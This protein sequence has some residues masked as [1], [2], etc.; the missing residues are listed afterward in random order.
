MQWLR[1]SLLV[2]RQGKQISFL[3]TQTSL[4]MTG[5]TAPEFHSLSSWFWE[6]DFSQ[7]SSGND[8]WENEGLL[9][10]Q[11]DF[12]C[13]PESGRKSD[14]L[15]CP[16]QQETCHK[17][18]LF[19]RHQNLRAHQVPHEK[20]QI[21]ETHQH[22]RTEVFPERD[23]CCSQPWLS[24]RCHRKKKRDSSPLTSFSLV[25]LLIVFPVFSACPHFLLS[26]LCSRPLS[27]VCLP[28]ETQPWGRLAANFASCLVYG[29]GKLHSHFL[30]FCLKLA[31]G[32]AYLSRTEILEVGRRVVAPLTSFPIIS[33]CVIIVTQNVDDNINTLSNS[34]NIRTFI[35]HSISEIL[36]D[37][38]VAT[39]ESW[40]GFDAKTLRIL[41]SKHHSVC[42]SLL[43][44]KMSVFL[45]PYWSLCSSHHQQI[46][47]RLW[48]A[49]SA[50]S[51]VP[52]PT[53]EGHVAEGRMW[54]VW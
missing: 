22:R 52:Q 26:S 44:K 14:F 39:A 18:K 25:F 3:E 43:C 17:M 54:I 49:L 8:I 36:H 29:S 6:D 16:R 48:T 38:F 30:R 50:I 5:S 20:V 53:C 4:E 46:R 10:K 21:V 28:R 40:M 12:L 24:L 51:D 47:I 34:T 33:F 13:I 37:S 27:S 15:S 7:K 11:T 9:R 41:I 2:G 31:T 1:K 23:Q 42:Q 32:V 19:K 45:Q 35:F